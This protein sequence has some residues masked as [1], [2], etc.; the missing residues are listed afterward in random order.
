VEW[1][2][3]EDGGLEGMP[4]RGVERWRDRGGKEG[5]GGTDGRRDG[6]GRRDGGTGR[7]GG[8][9]GW[10][11]GRTEMIPSKDFFGAFKYSTEFSEPKI[12]KNLFCNALRRSSSFPKMARP[13]PE[14]LSPSS[15]V[16]IS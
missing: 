14:A 10:R 3:E 9:E 5:R 4:G 15:S 13:P 6:E 2:K 8:T 16:S 11:G 7:D 12:S 1:R